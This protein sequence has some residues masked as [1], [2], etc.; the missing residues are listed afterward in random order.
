MT[1]MSATD[2]Q[3]QYVSLTRS[4]HVGGQRFCS[5]QWS[6]DTQSTWQVL[7]LQ[8]SAG[9]SAAASSTSWW[10]LDIGGFEPDP[11][12]SWSGNVDEPQFQELFVRWFEWG[13]FLPF[14]RVHGNR[15]CNVLTAF[16]C[17]NEPW[18]YG[19]E[20]LPILIDYINLRLSFKTYLTTIFTKLHETGRQ[21]MRPLIMDFGASDPNITEWTSTNDLTAP[22]NATTQQYL[23]GPKLLVIPVTL[24][25]VTTWEVYLPRTPNSTATEKPWTFWWTNET[26]AGGQVI[27]VPA[28]RAQIPLFHLGTREDL[29]NGNVF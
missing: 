2:P 5:V 8:I 26:F 3:C 16:T 4:S 7:A 24:P 25:N 9:L 15:A 14:M 12:V 19:P 6:G 27:T 29:L 11:T 22:V 18:T 23:L 28:P 17:S 10:T 20:N 13:T 21:I 1:G